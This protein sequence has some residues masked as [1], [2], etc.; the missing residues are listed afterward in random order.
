VR[1]FGAISQV[2]AAQGQSIISAI[3]TSNT[4]ASKSWMVASLAI[5]LLAGCVVDNAS[6]PTTQPTQRPRPTPTPDLQLMRAVEVVRAF[7]DAL[8]REDFSAAFGLLADSPRTALQS[9]DAL[10]RS[11]QAVGEA[12]LARSFYVQPRGGLLVQDGRAMATLA[13]LWESSIVGPF[14][15]TSTLV[16]TFTAAGWRVDWSPDA[17]IPGLANGVLRLDREAPVRGALYAADGTLLAVQQPYTVIGVQRGAIANANEETELLALLSQVTGL[18]PQAIKAKYADRPADWFSPIAELDDAAAH[19]YSALERFPAVSVRL[20]HRRIYPQPD[21]APHVVGFVGPIPPELLDAY[22]AL[23]YQGDEQIG[24]AGVEAAADG[25]LAGLPGGQLK[26][27]TNGSVTVIAARP[28]EPAQDVTLTISPPLQLAVQRLL[29]ARTGAVVVLRA[30]DSAVLAMA[31]WPTFSLGKQADARGALLNRATQG[32]YPAGS[33]FKMVTMSAAISEG[34]AQPT[35]VF[36][37]PG[38]WDGLGRAF[39]KTCWLRGGHGRISL[40]DGLTASCNVV[41]YTLGLRLHQRDPALLSAYARRFS[42]G[43]P[44]GVELP[45]AA[46]LVPDPDWKRRTLG[47]AWTIGDTVNLAIGQGFLLVT[48]LQVAQMTAA[49]ANGGSI[50]RPY[51]IA[52]PREADPQAQTLAPIAPTALAAIRHAMEGVT[53]NPRLGTATYRFADFDYCFQDGRFLACRELPARA[54]AGARRL[55]VA[56]KSGTAQAGGNARPFAWFTAYAPA[57]APELVVTVVL[58]DAGEGSNVAAPLVRQIIEAYYGLPISS[59]PSD[60][61]LSD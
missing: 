37:D 10:A 32:Q 31:S 17:I 23:G 47:E 33:T 7:A 24:L 1:V 51:V 8:N 28:P 18:P 57:D 5:V 45:E 52:A 35:E 53:R 25:V 15:V 59:T 48:P 41:F 46:G 20:F 36:R 6:V 22:R 58:E 39:R 21:L 50:R 34:L 16:L 42:F 19:A 26:L 3:S 55:I 9:P 29:G 49:L 44:T 14:V 61:R 54:R 27:F 12:S 2:F 60:R 11:Y 56:G 13:T 30:A 43:Q 40:R 38:Y 4:H